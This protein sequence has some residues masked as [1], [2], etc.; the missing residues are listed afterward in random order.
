[1]RAGRKK[2]V[3]PLRR[4]DPEYQS[5]TIHDRPQDRETYQDGDRSLSE[6]WRDRP[7]QDVEQPHM[8]ADPDIDAEESGEPAKR[9][10]T[11]TVVRR[12]V[13]EL[14]AESEEFGTAA[15]VTVADIAKRIV[16]PAKVRVVPKDEAEDGIELGGG[17]VLELPGRYH[18]ARRAIGGS[19]WASR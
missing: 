13:A 19:V 7:Y 17:E 14:A 5:W 16:A 15:S 2:A 1:M 18:A 11:E 3:P 4:A 10:N 12:V 6:L 9:L 8:D